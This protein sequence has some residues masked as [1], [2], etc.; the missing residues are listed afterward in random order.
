MEWKDSVRLK[1]ERTEY[2]DC[3]PRY[4]Y[5]IVGYGPNDERMCLSGHGNNPGEMRRRMD[6]LAERIIAERSHPCKVEHRY[7]NVVASDSASAGLRRIAQ[8]KQRGARIRRNLSAKGSW[9]R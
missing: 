9:Q 8:V 7:E 5:R 6:E 3:S 1:L 4:Q 2:P